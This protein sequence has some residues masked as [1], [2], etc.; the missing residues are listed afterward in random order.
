M[1]I[2]AKPVGRLKYARSCSTDLSPM[3]GSRYAR[4]ITGSRLTSG[5]SWKARNAA[6]MA[7]C[8]SKP[9]QSR[10]PADDQLTP[11]R[12]TTVNVRLRRNQSFAGPTTAL[13]RRAHVSHSAATG[14]SLRLAVSENTRL[15]YLMPPIEFVGVRSECQLRGKAGPAF[16]KRIPFEKFG[17]A[18]GFSP[19]SIDAMGD[20]C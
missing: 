20:R 6:R 3:G 10:R 15:S 16:S 17:I 8:G 2:S 12:R 4:T 18:G 9:S 7:G 14:Q 13:Q 19:G 5:R 11:F 1:I